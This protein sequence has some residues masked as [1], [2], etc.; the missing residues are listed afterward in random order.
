MEREQ[1]EMR[2]QELQQDFEVGERRLRDLEAQQA[3]LRDTLLRIDGAIQVL[4][5]LLSNAEMRNGTSS[6][7]ANGELGAT[8]GRSEAHHNP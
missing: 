1:L 5:E 2:L 4:R 7:E 6:A 3:Q 8:V